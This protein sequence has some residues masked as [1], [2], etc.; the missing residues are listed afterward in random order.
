MS[1]TIDELVAAYRNIRDAIKAKEEEHEAAL[2]V[3][4]ENLETV[5]QGLLDFCNEQNLDSVR[6][7]MGTVSRRV[8]TRYWTTDWDSTY[9]FIM[10]HEAL[11]LLEKRI[12]NT[13]MAQFLEENPDVL[14]PGLQIDRK[15]VVHVRKP[16][17]K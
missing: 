14:P 12:Q 13:N 4:K 6:T 9:Q 1:H 7:P 8:S 10:E 17:A 5:A 16:T 3:L 2:A 15:Y 11:H